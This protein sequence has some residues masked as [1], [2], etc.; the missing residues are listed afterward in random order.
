VTRPEHGEPTVDDLVA[1]AEQRRRSSEHLER[2]LASVTGTAHS[3]DGL[4]SATVTARGELRDLR[5]HPN[6]MRL[7]ADSLGRLIV[8]TARQA[9][10]FAAQRCYDVLAPVLGDELTAAVEAMTGTAPARAAGWD[11][12]ANMRPPL[13]AG[14]GAPVPAAGSS[15]GQ[16]GPGA[17][18]RN[19][20]SD[21]DH[22]PDDIFS[23]DPSTLRSDR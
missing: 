4:V 23:F 13:V 1:Q 10:E 21:D 8:Q 20:W 3:Q 19:S 18:R 16:H 7:D 15:P 11:A 5:L 22:D 9:A 17:G 6:V 14:H 2:A 12:A